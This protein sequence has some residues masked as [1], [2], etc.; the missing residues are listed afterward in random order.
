M[1]SKYISSKN[2][3]QGE[4]D[5]IWGSKKLLNRIVD[6]GRRIYHFRS[7]LILKKYI[8]VDNFCELGCGTSTLLLKVAKHVNHVTGIDYSKQALINSRMLF[9]KNCVKNATFLEDNCLNLKTK[10]KYDTVWSAGL[11]EHFEDPALVVKEHLKITKK[12]GYTIISVPYKFSYQYIWYLVTRPKLLRRLWPW[13]EQIF[14]T[15]K[16][17]TSTLRKYSKGENDY[18]IKIYPVLGLIILFVHKN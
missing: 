18:F 16:S 17:L 9:K 10:K 4:W 6:F 5:K 14:F 1:S 2:D 12:G 3:Q 13:T 11:I 7:M 15:K 8:N